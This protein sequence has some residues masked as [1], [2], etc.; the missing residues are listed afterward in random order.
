MPTESQKVWEE[1]FFNSQVLARVGLDIVRRRVAKRAEKEGFFLGK[2]K[3]KDLKGLLYLTRKKTN[4]IEAI[5]Q[6]MPDLIK[7]FNA[8]KHN[9]C[10][11]G[12]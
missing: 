5:R 6:T 3:E 2:H 10:L 7:R 11:E 12:Y 1:A 8:L 9:K 4:R